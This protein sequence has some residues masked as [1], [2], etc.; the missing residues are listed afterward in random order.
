MRPRTT[1]KKYYTQI[2][3]SISPLKQKFK[4][5]VAVSY[6]TKYNLIGMQFI[7]QFNWI[8]DYKN[9]T[10]FIK[11]INYKEQK[12]NYSKTIKVIAF[13]NYLIIGLKSKN[14]NKYH[15]GDTIVSVNNNKITKQNICFFE[16]LLNNEKDWNKFDILI[17]S[18]KHH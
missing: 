2:P 3:I 15:L 16:N 6:I 11:P 5:I 17:K 14:I 8:I 1:T 12:K 13:N 9:K 7:K 4:G 10:V 18:N